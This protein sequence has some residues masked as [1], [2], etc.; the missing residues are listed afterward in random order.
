MN[1]GEPEA[2]EL[3][4][5]GVREI[6]ENYNVDGIHFDGLFLSL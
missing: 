5:E 2:M 4:V 6:I 1:P 3:V